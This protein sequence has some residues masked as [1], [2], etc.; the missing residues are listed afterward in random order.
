MLKLFVRWLFSIYWMESFVF[1]KI[2]GELFVL[3]GFFEKRCMLV[4]FIFFCL[5]NFTK[6]KEWDWKYQKKTNKP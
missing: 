5:I 6:E 4:F 3:S 2:S 1:C